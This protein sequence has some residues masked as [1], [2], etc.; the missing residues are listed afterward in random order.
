MPE[1]S[2]TMVVALLAALL[3]TG[4]VA[5]DA[6]QAEDAPAEPAEGEQPAPLSN[7]EA[8]GLSMGE[9]E[10][11]IGQTYTKEEHGEWE[12]RCVRTEDG[13]DPCQLYQL[14]QDQDDNNV[15]EISIFPLPPG[16]QA[17]AGATVVTPLE[18]L[19]PAQLGLRVDS[20]EVKRYPFRTCSAIGCFSNIGFTADE[21][22]RF[23]RGASAT[24]TIR[25]AR[26]PDETVDLTLSLSGFTAGYESVAAA[27]AAVLEQQQE[28][29]Q[30]QQ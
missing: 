27:N 7:E 30:Q 9:E 11:Q 19:L 18:T 3:A 14:L 26:A 21:V 4:A 29:Q 17:V 10:S 2:R 6:G 23:R 15:A 8:L 1:L 12:V 24:L 22:V 16:G 13:N 20:G 25:P 28:Q 5:Q